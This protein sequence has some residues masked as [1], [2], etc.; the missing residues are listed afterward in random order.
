MSIISKKLVWS[1]VQQTRNR[2]EVIT[3]VGNTNAVHVMRQHTYTLFHGTE[4]FIKSHVN[5]YANTRFTLCMRCSQNKK[6]IDHNIARV[7][8][9]S[10][11]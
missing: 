5:V 9:R 3:E 10:N 6:L 4:F 11:C 7:H 2:L 8:R 1:Y